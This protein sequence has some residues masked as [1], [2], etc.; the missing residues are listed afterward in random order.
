MI[1]LIDFYKQP[2]HRLGGVADDDDDKNADRPVCRNWNIQVGR[3]VCMADDSCILHTYIG[4]EGK[5]GTM[6]VHM[7]VCVCV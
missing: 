3:Y 4:R 2:M 5:V 6:E 1:Q 7:C